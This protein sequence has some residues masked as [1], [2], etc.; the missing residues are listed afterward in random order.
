MKLQNVMLS[1]QQNFESS[2]RKINIATDIEPSII[3]KLNFDYYKSYF[4]NKDVLDIGCWSGQFEKL[5][6]PIT[7][8]MI[9]IDP[10][11][12]AIKVANEIVKLA[13][14][15]VMH[16][17]RLKFKR[18][19]F[20]TVS[21]FEVIEHVPKGSEEEILK[22]INYI[23]KPKGTLIITT[24]NAHFLSIVL[25]PAFFLFKHRHYK[26]EYLIELMLKSGFS[27][28]ELKYRGGLVGLLSDNLHIVWK[29]II[30]NNLP[31]FLQFNKLISH[32]YKSK[33]YATIH[34]VA[35]KNNTK[36]SK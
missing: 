4:K 1:N 34:L 6:A 5:A 27:I 33:G 30:G 16:A 20:D 15:Y 28:K 3:H 24:P 19:S 23:L 14:F 2:R 26:A 9:G 18:N 12:E 7:K 31:K 35:Q 13:K 22:K 36:T 8:K 17:E 10:G 32:E 11:V 29:Y 21:M 25:D